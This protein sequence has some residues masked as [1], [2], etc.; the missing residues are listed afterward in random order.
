MPHYSHDITD[1]ESTFEDLLIG[2]FILIACQVA[3]KGE[4]VQGS[5]LMYSPKPKS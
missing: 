4:L 2:A 3:G 1:T 5:M